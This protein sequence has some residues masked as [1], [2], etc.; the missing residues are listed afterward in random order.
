MGHIPA[1][2]ADQKPIV[3]KGCPVPLKGIVIHAPGSAR[4]NQTGP[5]RG[6]SLPENNIP[7]VQSCV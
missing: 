5:G 7:Q 1:G 6:R 3:Q 4:S 2:P